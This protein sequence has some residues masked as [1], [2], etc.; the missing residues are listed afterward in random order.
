MKIS[1]H[2]HP[3]II[4]CF[5]AGMNMSVIAMSHKV[6]GPT[7]KSILVDELSKKEFEF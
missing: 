2:K 4:A 1:K 7:I 6:T 5:K 3:M